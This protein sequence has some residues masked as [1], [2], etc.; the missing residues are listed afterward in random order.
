M[1]FFNIY[2]Y[3]LKNHYM[4]NFVNNFFKPTAVKYVLHKKTTNT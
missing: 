3:N 2:I 4:L 1:V